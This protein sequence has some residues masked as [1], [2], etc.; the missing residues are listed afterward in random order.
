MPDLCSGG[1]RFNPIQVILKTCDGDCWSKGKTKEI[2]LFYPCRVLTVEHDW[3]GCHIKCLR[4]SIPVRQHYICYRWAL[5]QYDCNNIESG[6][7]HVKLHKR[8]RQLV[9]IVKQEHCNNRKLGEASRWNPWCSP[10][11]SFDCSITLPVK[12]LLFHIDYNS[13]NLPKLLS[14]IF[15]KCICCLL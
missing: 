1:H 5:S 7:K 9:S 12:L 13:R 10:V 14:I 2:W 15:S 8:T 3:A 11:V 4:N 6:I